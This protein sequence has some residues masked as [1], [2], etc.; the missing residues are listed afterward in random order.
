MAHLGVDPAQVAR[1]ARELRQSVE[2][3]VARVAQLRCARSEY[4]QLHH[5]LRELP[6]RVEHEVMVPLCKVACVPGRLYHTNEIMVLLGDN[7]FALRSASQ[8]SEI[9]ERRARVVDEQLAVAEAELEQLETRLEQAEEVSRLA[10]QAAAEDVVDIREPYEE[11]RE[12]AASKEE[13]SRHGSAPPLLEQK[14]DARQTATT[15]DGAAP[16]ASGVAAA[17]E[18]SEPEVEKPA[19]PPTVSRFKAARMRAR[20]EMIP[21]EQ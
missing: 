20:G 17:T 3:Q 8:A 4:A 13:Q 19:A 15:S 7:H 1:L 9:C 2:E 21:G 5:T 11:E 16:M 6:G 14:A 12:E 18:P 10:E